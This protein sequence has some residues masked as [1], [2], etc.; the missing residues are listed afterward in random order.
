MLPQG[1]TP[2]TASSTQAK[3]VTE[4]ASPMAAADTTRSGPLFVCACI[5]LPVIWGVAVH[6]VF[7]RFRKKH[8]SAQRSK[9]TWPDYQI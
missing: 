9:P 8:R 3:Q 4:I 1:D 6:L 7:T 5:V 2:E